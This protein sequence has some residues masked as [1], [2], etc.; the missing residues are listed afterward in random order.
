M[1]ENVVNHALPIGTHKSIADLVAEG[2]SLAEVAAILDMSVIDVL[3]W[4]SEMAAV[5]HV[6][7]LPALAKRL[8][9][10]EYGKPTV[11][12]WRRDMFTGA[13]VVPQAPDAPAP[14]A[15]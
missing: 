12:P 3:R 6:R 8:R 11:S 14:L 4:Y 2:R 15:G 5:L 7:E 9:D 13:A 1:S 10:M